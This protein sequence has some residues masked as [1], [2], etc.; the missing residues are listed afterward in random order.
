MGHSSI[1]ITER[2]VQAIPDLQLE[3]AA[4][5]DSIL[6][7]ARETAHEPEGGRSGGVR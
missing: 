2:Y 1:T 4:R 5:M 3:A 6:R 7:T